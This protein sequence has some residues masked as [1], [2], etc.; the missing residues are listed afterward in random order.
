MRQCAISVFFLLLFASCL[1]EE[2]D[3]E[4]VEWLFFHRERSGCNYLSIVEGI[5]GDEYFRDHDQWTINDLLNNV[6]FHL[7]L[8]IGA[9]SGQIPD[10]FLHSETF[11]FKSWFD[12]LMLFEARTSKFAF[13]TLFPDIP[14]DAIVKEEN[15]VKK[16]ECRQLSFRK[17]KRIT[18]PEDLVLQILGLSSDP[19]KLPE[20][21]KV[22][23]FKQ[24]F[25][26]SLQIRLSENSNYF[27]IIG[28]RIVG[29]LVH[30]HLSRGKVIIV[31][32]G[33]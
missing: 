12:S 11:K 4:P 19:S 26:D 32:P 1:G 3:R 18:A 27:S 7:N 29:E 24:E 8:N 15:R 33:E 22:E 6:R 30:M 20:T 25:G 13:G 17:H 2:S 31:V 10:G 23:L 16:F 21:K 9:P 14:M 5:S 28:P